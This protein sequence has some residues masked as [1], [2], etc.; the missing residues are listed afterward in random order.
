MKHIE[1][2]QK[3]PKKNI[4]NVLFGEDT[5]S[6]FACG[7]KLSRE[8]IETGKC[9]YCGTELPKKDVKLK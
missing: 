4:E 5:R 9:P 6:C 3:E 8:D 2:E 7:E 1:N